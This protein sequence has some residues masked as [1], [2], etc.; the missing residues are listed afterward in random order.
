GRA[1]ALAGFVLLAAGAACWAVT[2]EEVDAHPEAWQPMSAWIA[3]PAGI[4]LLIGIILLCA[5]F[6]RNNVTADGELRS[7]SGDRPVT[8]IPDGTGHIH[9]H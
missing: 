5:R 2:P 3:A 8:P 6:V 1:I 4:F 9:F 7:E